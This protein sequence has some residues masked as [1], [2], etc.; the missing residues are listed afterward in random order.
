MAKG[1]KPLTKVKNVHKKTTKF[2]RYQA[3]TFLRISRTSW[4]KP[5]GIDGKQR[6]RF[7]GTPRM[8]KI[9]YGTDKR[10]R[11]YLPNGFLKFR[12]TNLEDLELLLMHN[13]TYCAEIA[14]KVGAKTRK[15]I[16]ARAAALGVR[17]TNANARL[18]AEDDE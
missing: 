13:R 11:H 8:P 7:K 16:V 2:K 1:A 4:R 9:G 3:D 6:R 5:K 15:Q 12:V 18:R 14:S 17:V 10:T